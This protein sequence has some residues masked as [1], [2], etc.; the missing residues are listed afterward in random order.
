MYL[1]QYATVSFP[2]HV[3]SLKMKD[4][5]FCSV[6]VLFSLV[7]FKA[8]I[9]KLDAAVVAQPGLH[10]LCDLLI[11][12]PA[13]AA[14]LCALLALLSLPPHVPD[15]PLQS[16]LLRPVPGTQQPHLTPDGRMLHILHLEQYIIH[17][18]YILMLLT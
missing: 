4:F 8:F 13:L 14:G 7:Q 17:T 15:E 16:D 5:Q 3:S 10:G 12:G 2:I 1:L 9:N 6:Y 11:P 18:L